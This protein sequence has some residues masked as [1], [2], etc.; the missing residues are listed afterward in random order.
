MERIK[1]YVRNSSFHGFHYMADPNRH[2][3]ERYSLLNP[4]PFVV[5]I[6]QYNEIIFRRVFWALVFCI[7]GYYMRSFLKNVF[8]VFQHYSVNLVMDTDYLEW[9][10]TF[11][12][13]SVCE[14]ESPD[15]L[16]EVCKKYVIFKILKRKEQE[17][18]FLFT[19][20]TRSYVRSIF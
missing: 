18:F 20:L 11:P 7:S 9:N 10:T 14:H 17:F 2:W 15:K 8:D 12:A 4:L 19:I 1:E 13:I 5:F 16:F 6:F 3:S